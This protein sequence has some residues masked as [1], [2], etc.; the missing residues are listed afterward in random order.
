MMGFVVFITLR[1]H[2][3][4]IIFSES[5]NKYYVGESHNVEGR[6]VKHNKHVYKGAFSNITNDWR[7]VLSK[8]CTSKD[9]ALFLESFIKRMK[10]KK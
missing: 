5:L 8:K 9:D 3:L 1:M 4:Y 6:L 7:I 2:Y 10:S